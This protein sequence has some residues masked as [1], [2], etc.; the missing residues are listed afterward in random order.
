MTRQPLRGR[1]QGGKERWGF[2]CTWP[3][4]NTG[5]QALTLL[6]V[7]NPSIIYSL[8][9]VS[10]IPLY[11][12]LHICGFNQQGCCSTIVFTIEKKS[13]YKWTHA[14]QI[15]VVQ[16]STVFGNL[17]FLIYEREK[18]RNCGKILNLSNLCGRFRGVSYYFP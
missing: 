4:N 3:L 10:A 11:P 9:S 14:V 18:R 6:T 1:K 2:R 17:Y 5:V 12:R 16:G 7:E 8:P 13:T 15:H